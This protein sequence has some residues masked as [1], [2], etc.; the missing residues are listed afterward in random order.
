MAQ[1][2]DAAIE[3]EGTRSPEALEILKK[4]DQAIKAVHSV[5]CQIVTRSTGFAERFAP[6]NEGA[7]VMVGWTGNIPEMFYADLEIKQQ[8]SD[9][10]GHLTGGGNGDTFF[11]I[12]HA[13][14]KGYEDMDPSVMGS[15]GRTLRGAGMIEFVHDAPFDDELEAHTVE[16]EGEQTID[17]QPCY[18][19]H[20]V[21]AGGQGE[22]TWYFS[23]KDYLP[24]RRVRHLSRPGM[25]EGTIE[26][27]V[28]RLELNIEPEANL[29]LMDL[30]EGYERVDDFA[31]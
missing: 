17:G 14:K 28:S 15:A 1:E 18:Q 7:T 29:F 25:G 6:S 21:Y 9:E 20:V 30:P 10:M 19:I 27:S 8:D 22:S 13:T 31:P 24:R 3:D 26:T 5:R 4:A 12:D 11:V 2:A 23:K 16:L